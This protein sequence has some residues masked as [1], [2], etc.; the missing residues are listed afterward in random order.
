MFMRINTIYF[1]DAVLRVCVCVCAI[2]STHNLTLGYALFV[3][4]GF[5]RVGIINDDYITQCF[6]MR[7]L[8][9]ILLWDL[10]VS[11]YTPYSPSTHTHTTFSSATILSQF[12]HTTVHSR[13]R[14]VHTFCG[15]VR[16]LYAYETTNF[17]LLSYSFIDIQALYSRAPFSRKGVA[18]R[19]SCTC[20]LFSLHLIH[21]VH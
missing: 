11:Y 16:L 18:T 15:R 20:H 21:I 8:T 9:F 13:T 10:S 7:T 2:V 12:I 3:C 17:S 19:V 14:N 1:N 4:N 5:N 6:A